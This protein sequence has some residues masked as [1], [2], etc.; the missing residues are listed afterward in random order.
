M[1]FAVRFYDKP[2]RSDV[3]KEQLQA[4]VKWLGLHKGIVLVGG[5]LR[6][7]ADGFPVGGLWIV[8]AEN[9]AHVE[10]LLKSD[11]FWVHGLRES[12]EILHW[13]KAFPEEKVLV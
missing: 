1:L 12:H 6:L 13:Q 9:I 8:E 7:V 5:S 11:P 2:D 4:H 3:R 10:S